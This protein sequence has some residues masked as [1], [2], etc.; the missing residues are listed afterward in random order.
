M[1]LRT[2]YLRDNLYLKIMVFSCRPILFE[3]CDSYESG[4][5][6][7]P[8]TELESYALELQMKRVRAYTDRK[9]YLCAVQGSLDFQTD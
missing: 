4:F 5:M 2:G 6:G 3:S 1:K 9:F 7:F 8:A